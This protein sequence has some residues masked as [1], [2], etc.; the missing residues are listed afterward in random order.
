MWSLIK[1]KE[2][3]GLM[4]LTLSSRLKE[5]AQYT[6]ASSSYELETNFKK[7]LEHEMPKKNDIRA[8]HS[9]KMVIKTEL[10][11]EIWKLDIKGDLK[12]KLFTLNYEKA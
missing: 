11:A 1:N 8:W 3:K 10:T 4:E 12:H 2:P 6:Y 7:I 5:M 9:F